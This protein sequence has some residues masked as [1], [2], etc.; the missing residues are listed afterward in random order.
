MLRNCC[1]RVTKLCNLLFNQKLFDASFTCILCRRAS[2][3]SDYF[4]LQYI[5][6]FHAIL[7]WQWA[8][9]NW[10][11]SQERGPSIAFLEFWLKRIAFLNLSTSIIWLGHCWANIMLGLLI[12]TSSITLSWL[13]YFLEI[14]SL[15]GNERNDFEFRAKCSEIFAK[16]Y[17]LRYATHY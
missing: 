7:L 12:R 11:R 14:V 17:W 16:L 5:F 9:V 15:G 4:F 1:V 10:Y 3:N 2:L 6:V 8:F 13:D